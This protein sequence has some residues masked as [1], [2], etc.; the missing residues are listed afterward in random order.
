MY[1]SFLICHALESKLLAKP[2]QTSDS[3]LAGAYHLQVQAPHSLWLCSNLFFIYKQRIGTIPTLQTLIGKPAREKEHPVYFCGSLEEALDLANGELS[4][5]GGRCTA[6]TGN[7]L[8]RHPDFSRDTCVCV[9]RKQIILYTDPDPDPSYHFDAH[10]YPDLGPI[11]CDTCYLGTLCQKWLKIT[12]SAFAGNF[13]VRAASTVIRV[14]EPE[15]EPEPAFFGPPR[16]RA[17]K[18]LRLRSKL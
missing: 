4:G 15:R 17:V 14:A 6:R 13:A 12:R 16:A 18:L 10:P 2:N 11:L 9:W 7:I 3:L 1:L 8:H 5:Q